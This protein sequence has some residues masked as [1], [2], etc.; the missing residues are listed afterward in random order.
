MMVH[1]PVPNAIKPINK[2]GI[3]QR[4]V[5]DPVLLSLAI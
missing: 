3:Y 1:K 2:I 4:T 5:I